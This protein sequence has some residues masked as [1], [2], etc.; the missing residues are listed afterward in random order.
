M[1]D[2]SGNLAAMLNDPMVMQ[3][4]DAKKALNQASRDLEKMASAFQ[5]MTKNMSHA[6]TGRR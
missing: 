5:S 2:M 4:R 1:R 3:Q 6:M